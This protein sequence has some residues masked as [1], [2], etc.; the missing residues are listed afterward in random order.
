MARASQLHEENIMHPTALA[1]LVSLHI[2]E[3][4]DE[5]PTGDRTPTSHDRRRARHGRA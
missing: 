1:Y 4:R 2:A 3:L 5:V